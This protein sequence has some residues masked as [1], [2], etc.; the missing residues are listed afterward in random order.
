MDPTTGGCSATT[1]VTT[2][3]GVGSTTPANYA[4]DGTVPCG[5]GQPPGSSF[6]IY[7]LAA[8]AERGHRLRH[9]LELTHKKIGGDT[10][11]NAEPQRT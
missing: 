4:E 8:G 5:G 11:N 1:A 10:I 7:T 6:K 2:G 9:H 3:D